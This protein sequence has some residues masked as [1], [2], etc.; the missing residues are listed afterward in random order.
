LGDSAGWELLHHVLE[1]PFGSS[2]F[3]VDVEN[4]AF[5]F[6]R[7]PDLRHPP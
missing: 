6:G 4:G 5:R 1:L 2:A 7:K 3:L